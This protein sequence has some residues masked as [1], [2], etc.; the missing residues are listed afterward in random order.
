MMSLWI[1]NQKVDV[2]AAVY[3]NGLA[4]VD[5]GTTNFELPATAFYQL[6]KSFQKL[7]DGPNP[8]MIGICGKSKYKSMF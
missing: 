4:I 8:N 7:C 3:N 2:D 6:E 5:S 1:G